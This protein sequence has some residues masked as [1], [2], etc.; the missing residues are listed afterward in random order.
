MPLQL[1]GSFDCVVL[2]CIGFQGAVHLQGHDKLPEDAI[3]DVHSRII[4]S[5]LQDGTRQGVCDKPMLGR[6]ML[7][8]C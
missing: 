7:F 2:G 3:L 8:V 4:V 6:G 5:S 1:A